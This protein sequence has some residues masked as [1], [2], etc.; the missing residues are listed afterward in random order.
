MSGKLADNNL[1]ILKQLQDFLNIASASTAVKTNALLTQSPEMADQLFNMLKPA[2]TGVLNTMPIG[3][4]DAKN[5]PMYSKA[6]YFYGCAWVCRSIIEEGMSNG[7]APD[8]TALERLKA[9]P[10]LNMTEGW[11]NKAGVVQK[12]Q[13]D[14]GKAPKY[15][16]QK[17]SEKLMGRRLCKVCGI[18][19]CDEI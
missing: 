7:T 11:W 19:P 18:Y 12:I 8:W 1:F 6:I 15:M 16:M 3:E 2:L 9:L 10:L 17:G 4:T 5:D 14:N 13:L